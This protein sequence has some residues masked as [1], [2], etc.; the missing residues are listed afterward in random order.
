[1]FSIII[2]FK[3]RLPFL[4]EAI[5][6]LKVQTFEDWECILVN[7][8]E[9]EPIP[10]EIKEIISEDGRFR[11]YARTSAYAPGANGARNMGADMAKFDLLIFHDADD[12]WAADALERR[13]AYVNKH[14]EMDFW[15]FPSLMFYNIPGETDLLWN[16]L[17]SN[18][19]DLER[20]L[21]FESVWQTAG[22]TYYKRFF[23]KIGKWDETLYCLQDWEMGIRSLWHTNT[24]AKAWEY[25]PDHYYRQHSTGSIS[26]KGHDKFRLK[27]LM[28]AFSAIKHL[29]EKTDPNLANKFDALVLQHLTTKGLKS[30][31]LFKMIKIG[32]DPDFYSGISRIQYIFSL[33]QSKMKMY[34][35]SK[36]LFPNRNQKQVNA[37][38]NLKN[39]TRKYT[40]SDMGIK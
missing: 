14:P 15:V 25:Y 11:Y 9:G 17:N 33:L 24:Y 13:A 19:N 10:D 18:K 16:L 21:H 3:D 22:A 30:F 7:D 6:S 20:F 38:F 34:S 28:N 39:G 40:L 31:G 29:L 23:N 8:R 27:G 4:M 2:P 5:D 12:L 1:M 26:S 36:Y 37:K 32:I 35:F